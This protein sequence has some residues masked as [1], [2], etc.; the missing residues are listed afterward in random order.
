VNSGRRG[1]DLAIL[2]LI[3]AWLVQQREATVQHHGYLAAE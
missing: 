3:E 1:R 2:N